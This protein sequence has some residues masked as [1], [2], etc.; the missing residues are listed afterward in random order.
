MVVYEEDVMA[1]GPREGVSG[2]GRHGRSADQPAPRAA[3]VKRAAPV[4]ADPAT[5]PVD[6]PTTCTATVSDT[7]S[8]TKSSPTGTVSFT[9]SGRG[10]FSGGGSATLSPTATPGE[11]SCSLS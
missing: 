1:Q 2:D 5:V 9:S 6:S 3:A 7:G 4:T 11:A 10:S 8:G